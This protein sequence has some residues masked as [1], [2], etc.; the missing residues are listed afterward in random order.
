MQLYLGTSLTLKQIY[1]QNINM[2]FFWLGIFES[3]RIIELL[4]EIIK[5]Q[6]SAKPTSNHHEAE[7]YKLKVGTAVDQ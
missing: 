1:I 2:D 5:E 3:D 4:K 6:M 7:E